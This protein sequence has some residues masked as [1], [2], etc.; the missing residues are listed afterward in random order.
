MLDGSPQLT[1]IVL[2]TGLFP[3]FPIGLNV[4]VGSFP[5]HEKGFGGGVH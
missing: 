4:I 2:G 3:Q 5:W 1:E